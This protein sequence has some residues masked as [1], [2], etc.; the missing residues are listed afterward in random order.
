MLSWICKLDDNLIEYKFLC[1]NKNYHKS[2]DENLKKRFGIAHKCSKYINKFILL[3]RR[4]V[5]I[6]MN[7]WM[8]RKK[9]QWHI[10]VWE[11]RFLQSPKHGRRSYTHAKRV[12]NN[13]EKKNLGEYHDLYLQS[14]T[15]FLVDVFNNSWNKCIEI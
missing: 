11:R 13:F 7:T 3:L 4:K 5:F 8:I 12:C 10:I 9:T 6:P 14:D 2:F 1:R 15:L